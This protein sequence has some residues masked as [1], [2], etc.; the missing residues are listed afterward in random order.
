M[1][2]VIL[3]CAVTLD[4]YIARPDGSVDYLVMTREGM[5]F[6]TKFFATVDTIIMGRKTLDAAKAMS[7][8]SYQSPVPGMPTYVFSRSQPTGGRDGI[9]FTNQ[10]PAALVRQLRARPGKHICHMGGGELARGFLE[11]DLVDEL[12]LHV[13]PILLGSGIPLFPAG[14][15]QRDFTLVENGDSKSQL[16]LTYRRLRSKA[17]RKGRKA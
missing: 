5:R 3:T 14:F 16:Y 8:G 9:I 13:A 15:P 1:R 17:K 12:F 7:G 10:S 4:G 6:L 2:K 11:A